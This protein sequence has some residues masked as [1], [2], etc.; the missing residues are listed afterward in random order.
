MTQNELTQLGLKVCKNV[1]ADFSSKYGLDYDEIYSYALEKLSKIFPKVRDDLKP[2]RYISM[3]LKGNLLNY[4]RDES[5]PVRVPRRLNNLYLERNRLLKQNPNLESPE[6]R[7]ELRI[8][9][10]TLHQVENLS[11][12]NFTTDLDSCEFYLSSDNYSDGVNYIRHNIS[13]EDRELLE[14]LYLERMNPTKLTKKWGQDLGSLQE[15]ANQL[16]EELKIYT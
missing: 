11:S 6:I 3:S 14:D 4:I 9:E 10:D 13:L 16:V 8:D 15:R 2:E 5:R 7:R 12:S 1:C